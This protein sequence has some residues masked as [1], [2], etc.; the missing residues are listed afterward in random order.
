MQI[1]LLPDAKKDIEFWTK[2]GN[3]RILGKITQLLEAIL[4]NPYK[5]L[6][7]PEQLK[8]E[9]S[10]FWSR[11]ID[12][13]HRMIYEILDAQVLVHSAKGHYV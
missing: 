6:G 4:T 2:S 7:K 8:H 10:G 13:E 1:V 12:K 9:L 3:K 11:R 5:G